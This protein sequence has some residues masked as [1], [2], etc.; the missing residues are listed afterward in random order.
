M[1]T[2][3]ALPN[4]DEI[5]KKFTI[6]YV[7]FRPFLSNL[8]GEKEIDLCTILPLFAVPPSSSTIAET[9]LSV[10]TSSVIV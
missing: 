3:T 5:S 10:P 2:H 7:S 4:L 1:P 6:R 8:S 9:P